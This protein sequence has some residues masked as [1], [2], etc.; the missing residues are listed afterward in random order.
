MHGDPQ[1]NFEAFANRSP[2]DLKAHR[3]GNASHLAEV[4][5]QA[6]FPEHLIV[7]MVTKIDSLGLQPNSR[8]NDAGANL[9]AASG[10]IDAAV[11]LYM[12]TER[13]CTI[14]SISLAR[15]ALETVGRAA[16]ITSA[17]V[18]VLERWETG[19]RI[20]AADCIRALAPL[21]PT[22][23]ANPCGPGIVYA[24]LCKYAHFNRA[25]VERYIAAEPVQEPAYAAIAYASWALAVVTEHVTGVPGLARWPSAWPSPFPWQP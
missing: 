16:L 23:P 20:P 13:V 1:S 5:T 15:T 18:R 9:I 7:G 17:P 2:I 22:Q 8:A 6:L 12:R 10:I 21:V 19:E 11:V 4:Y 24:W 25:T 3:V 14:S